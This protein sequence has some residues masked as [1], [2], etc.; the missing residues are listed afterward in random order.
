MDIL[1]LLEGTKYNYGYCI[2][3]GES[4][5]NPCTGDCDVN[6]AIDALRS[7]RVVMVEKPQEDARVFK[8]GDLI[9]MTDEGYEMFDRKRPYASGVVAGFSRNGIRVKEDNRV[10]VTSWHKSFW[11][12]KKEQGE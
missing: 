6:Q 2:G 11:R 8:K 9:E 10:A 5:K 3:C 7:G 4:E 1:N 12:L